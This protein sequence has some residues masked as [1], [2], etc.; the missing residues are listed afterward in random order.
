MLFTLKD[1]AYGNIGHLTE[2]SSS[3]RG[4]RPLPFLHG[5]A[6]RVS[7][8]AGPREVPRGQGLNYSAPTARNR[9]LVDSARRLSGEGDSGRHPNLREDV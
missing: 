9:L 3:Q 4:L 1:W 6:Q 8:L 7:R 5:K 2:S